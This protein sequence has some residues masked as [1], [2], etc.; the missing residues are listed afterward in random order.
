M[1]GDVN[2][3]SLLA[4]LSVFT[5]PGIQGVGPG[6]KP[7]ICCQFAYIVVQRKTLDNLKAFRQKASRCASLEDEG[8]TSLVTFMVRKNFV[9]R[10]VVHKIE[11][12]I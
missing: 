6:R 7:L 8:R 5:S 4:E 9:V 10:F 11:S 2:P 3:L 12:I 1:P